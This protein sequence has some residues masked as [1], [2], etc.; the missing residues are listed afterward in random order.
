MARQTE[1]P[2]TYEFFILTENQTN[3]ANLVGTSSYAAELMKS[4]R[5]QLTV[6]GAAWSGDAAAAWS[7]YISTVEKEFGSAVKLL[8][9]VF[10]AL[11]RYAHDVEPVRRRY[12]EAKGRAAAYH[13]AAVALR[14]GQGT[15]ADS[16]L[17]ESWYQELY[18]QLI[19]WARNVRGEEAIRAA[20]RL[21]GLAADQERM[22]AEALREGKE[23]ARSM[24]SALG[25]FTEQ[26]RALMRFGLPG[27]ASDDDVDAARTAQVQAMA[28]PLLAGMD[29]STLAGAV[30]VLAAIGTNRRLGRRFQTTVLREL[31]LRENGKVYD[32]KINI[33]GVP[34]TVGVQPDA[35][36][37]NVVI[38]VKFK[39]FFRSKP[40]ELTDQLRGMMRVAGRGNFVLVIG[41]K[42][43]LDP[44]LTAEI[45]K[46][47][48]TVLRRLSENTYEDLSGRRWQ[49]T[50]EGWTK[51][52]ANGRPVGS[53]TPN[54]PL[55]ER[56]APRPSPRVGVP[57][58]PPVRV[59]P[60]RV[61]PI[62][63]Q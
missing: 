50:R 49:V 11:L 32:V 30:A 47:E 29:T 51:L 34:K 54:G 33:N 46:L 1:F 12:E 31:R 22:A 9:Q 23:K 3:L 5:N 35:M 24:V 21:D 36:N 61:P 28:G 63:R 55:P 52:D 48:N 25:A 10:P 14:G 6:G 4:T 40:L 45:N 38:E 18:G 8:E 27:S 42:V 60:V 43:R 37:G 20:D 7:S 13:N 19:G 58:P 41:P 39:R 44:R 26:V 62:D 2:Q 17:G 57:R 53:T 16:S 15:Q 59:P 56:T